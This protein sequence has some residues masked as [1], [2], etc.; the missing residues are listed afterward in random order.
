MLG[1]SKNTAM[2]AAAATGLSV[3]LS[4]SIVLLLV[5]MLGGQPDGPGFWMSVLC[6]LVIA[7]PASTWQFH[8]NET[9]ARQ[10]DELARMH[11]ELEDMHMELR[12]LHEDLRWRARRDALTGGLNREAMFAALEQAAAR[13]EGP[14]ML[15]VIDADHFKR[16]NDE[17][18]HLVGD[19]ALR[20]LA[21]AID[22]TV[23]ASDL[24]GRV[25]GEEFLVFLR[26]VS[27]EQAVAVARRIRRAVSQASFA[28]AGR[29]VPLSVSIGAASTSGSFDPTALFRSAD[30]DLYAAKN[31]GRDRIVIDGKLLDP[32]AA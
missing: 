15:L 27:H 4:V 1:I 31:A 18:G 11:V 20:R 14:G 30:E 29:P 28:S 16:I 23:A 10:R 2:K 19:E 22:A 7:G 24:W 9:I 5:P 25:G 6:P 32:L 3:V 12:R 17:F 21:A 26:D 8:Q 13:Q